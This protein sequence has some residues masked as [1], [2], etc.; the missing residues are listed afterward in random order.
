MKDMHD[1]MFQASPDIR[2]LHNLT[3]DGYRE[4]VCRHMR[5][6]YPS[7]EECYNVIRPRLAWLAAMDR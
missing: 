6:F 1:R 3:W 5:H 4:M 2:P 7:T